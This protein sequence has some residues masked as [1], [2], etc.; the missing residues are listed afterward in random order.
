M[1]A[2]LNQN[3]RNHSVKKDKRTQKLGRPEASKRHG[4]MIQT[5]RATV[6]KHQVAILIQERGLKEM[7]ECKILL[8]LFTER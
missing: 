6:D 4:L 1:G 5:T 2:F 7:T 3:S 8:A